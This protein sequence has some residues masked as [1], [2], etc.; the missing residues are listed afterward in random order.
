MQ[1]RNDI[2]AL[3]RVS[4]AKPAG[5]ASRTHRAQRFALLKRLARVIS[6]TITSLGGPKVPLIEVAL[7]GQLSD[8]VH[9]GE[10]PSDPPGSYDL[11]VGHLAQSPK[12]LC[13]LHFS[14]GRWE[15][16]DAQ[17]G[18]RR[19]FKAAPETLQHQGRRKSIRCNHFHTQERRL[20]SCR[21]MLQ[22]QIK[23]WP[24]QRGFREGN[25][26]CVRVE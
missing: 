3:C 17:A 21:F 19:R 8:M 5:E 14:E 20:C 22:P 10:Y 24:Y 13:Q 26:S 12:V 9:A 23:E 1:L 7:L 15:V 18:G 25:K 16:L 11:G 6:M 4:P 2:T